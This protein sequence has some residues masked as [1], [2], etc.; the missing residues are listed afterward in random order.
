M[1]VT[2]IVDASHCGQTGAAGCG[3]WIACERGK[4][5]GEHAF[6]KPVV[7]AGVAEFMGIVASLQSAIARGLVQSGDSVLMQSDCM[8]AIALARGIREPNVQENEYAIMLKRIIRTFDLT[9]KYKHVK[10][11]K[12]D[13]IGARYE[14]IELCDQRAK[15][16]MRNRRATFA[17]DRKAINQIQESLI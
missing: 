10:A 15:H 14:T 5:P 13:L 4:Q 11:H 8:G 7:N 12:K 1:N 16:A 6:R 9:V 3:F 2:I 17:E